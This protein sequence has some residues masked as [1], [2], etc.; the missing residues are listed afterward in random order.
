MVMLARKETVEE[1]ISAAAGHGIDCHAIGEV[2]D[3][4][5]SQRVQ[6]KP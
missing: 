6:F 4:S 1:L 5:G 3:G 2:T